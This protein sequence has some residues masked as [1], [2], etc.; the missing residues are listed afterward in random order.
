M[1][2]CLAA[3]REFHL[4]HGFPAGSVRPGDCPQTDLVRLHLIGEE[5]A[6]LAL[7]LAERDP[8]RTA[9][10]LGD[11]AYVVFGTAVAYG[12][13]LAEVFE[14][15]QRSN[16]TKA[17]RRPG[18]TRL[19]NKGEGYSPPDVAGVLTRYGYLVSNGG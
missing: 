11:L 5:L 2:K 7:A 6:E 12:I 9:D 1:E 15:V 18:D 17:V 4:K 19:R 3:V 14:E 10:A 13:P 8:V 16:M